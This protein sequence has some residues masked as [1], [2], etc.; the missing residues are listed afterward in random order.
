MQVFREEMG[1]RRGKSEHSCQIS[2][3]TDSWN[4]FHT[5]GQKKSEE[6]MNYFTLKIYK[7]DYAFDY[8]HIGCKTKAQVMSWFRA[9]ISFVYAMKT[10]DSCVERAIS[11]L[12][13]DHTF[14]SDYPQNTQVKVNNLFT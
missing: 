12:E 6:S 2:K 11:V 9:F 1:E 10:K 14:L 4:S 7:Q 8:I 13:P 5:R 3:S